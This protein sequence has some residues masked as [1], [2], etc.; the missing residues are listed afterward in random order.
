MVDSAP[1]PS[2]C[3][4]VSVVKTADGSLEAFF[5]HLFFAYITIGTHKVR[6]A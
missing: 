6:Y 1:P 2:P 4:T 3:F 5:V